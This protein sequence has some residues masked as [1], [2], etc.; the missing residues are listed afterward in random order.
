MI[1]AIS[2]RNEGLTVNVFP[3]EVRARLG[4]EPDQDPAVG[5]A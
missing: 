3:V 5:Q 4:R 2:D 1:R